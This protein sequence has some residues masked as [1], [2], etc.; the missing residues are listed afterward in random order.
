MAKCTAKSKQSGE[1]CRRDAAPG[2]TVCSMHGGKAP[3]VI[4]AAERRV[5]EAENRRA[6]EHAVRDAYGDTV[7]PVDPVQAMLEAVSRK[8][9]EVQFLRAQVAQLSSDELVWG[10]TKKKSGGEDFGTTQEAKPNIWLAMLHEA[11]RDLVK[12]A[13]EARARGCDEHLVRIA[14]HTG[15]Q[16]ALVIRAVLDRLSLTDQQQ[17]LVGTVVPEELRALTAPKETP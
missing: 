16:V 8:A 1:R 13:S 3:Q 14:E 4:N 12:F 10:V 11:E 9:L 7:P 15:Q 2:A 17:A 5:Q 6:L